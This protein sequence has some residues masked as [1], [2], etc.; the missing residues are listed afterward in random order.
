MY[1]LNGN[2][3][4]QFCNALELFSDGEIVAGSVLC[5]FINKVNNAINSENGK[6]TMFS[7]CLRNDFFVVAV[8][9]WIMKVQKKNCAFW[10]FFPSV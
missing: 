9:F 2:E 10:W 6:Q 4:I 5:S 8:V 1:I 3:D 7:L